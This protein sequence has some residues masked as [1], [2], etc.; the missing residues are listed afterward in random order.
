MAGGSPP[1]PVCL[2]GHLIPMGENSGG[3]G[4]DTRYWV[5]TNPSC[6]YQISPFKDRKVIYKHL[7]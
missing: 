2:K 4:A 5:C 6:N 7:E 3:T 1:C